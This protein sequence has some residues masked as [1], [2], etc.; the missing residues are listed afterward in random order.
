MVVDALASQNIDCEVGS[1]IE[2]H[3]G[4]RRRAVFAARKTQKGVLFGFHQAQTHRIVSISECPVLEPAIESKID[5]LRQLSALLAAGTKP[6]RLTVLATESGLDVTAHSV[7]LNEKLRRNAIALAL[8]SD[9]ARLAIEDE[10]LIEARKPLLTISGAR[11][12]PPPG[13]FVQA[14]ATAQSTMTGMVLDHLSGLKRTADLFAGCGAF[15]L[16]MARHASVLAAESEGPSLDALDQAARHTQGLRPVTAERRDLFRRPLRPEELK[17]IGGVVFDPP[18]AGAQAQA[19]EL[20]RSGVQKIVAVSCNPVTLARDLRI[21]IDG[22]FQL[23]SVTP[24]DQFLWSPHVE[25]VALLE[26]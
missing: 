18:R 6:F 5:D 8:K 26:R 13:A 9:L 25:A 2:C 7:R 21:L 19:T 1:T 10:V 22:G 12:H 16:S 11:L 15:A 20:A 3:P 24:I 17:P 14:S 4:S 23:K